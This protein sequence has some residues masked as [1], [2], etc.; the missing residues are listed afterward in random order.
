M[1]NS[2]IRAA[3]L[4]LVALALAGC[5]RDKAVEAHNASP[6]AVASK[7]AAA[8]IRL[9]PGR[10][11]STTRIEKMDMG[12]MPPEARAM[13]QKALGTEQHMATCLTPEQAAK[14]KGDF[15]HGDPS[16]TYEHFA[17]GGG[18]IDAAMTCKRP[19]GTQRMTVAGSYDAQTYQ[20]HVTSEGST[21]PGMPMNMAMAITAH[22]VGDCTGKE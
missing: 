11:E 8:D 6:Q 15:F 7:V 5:N 19:S 2:L 12:Q 14:P 13:M 21:G 4:G 18:K 22:R 10:W 17:M 20:M 9:A 16:C 1:R 3:G